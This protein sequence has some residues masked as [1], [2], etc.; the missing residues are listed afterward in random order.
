MAAVKG[1]DAVMGEGVVKEHEDEEEGVADQ[2]A[3]RQSRW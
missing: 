2:P 1:E 3:R